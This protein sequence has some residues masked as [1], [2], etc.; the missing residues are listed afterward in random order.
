MWESFK[1]WLNSW[2]KSGTIILAR[3]QVVVG[4]LFAAAQATDMSPIIP[5]KYLPLWLIVSGA[6]TEIIRHWND[7]TL[8]E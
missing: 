2:K 1:G 4:A 6:L 3:A 7:P 8:R 5:A